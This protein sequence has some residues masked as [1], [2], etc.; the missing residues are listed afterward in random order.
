MKLEKLL[1][2]NHS[3]SV[4]PQPA[5]AY[6]GQCTCTRIVAPCEASAAMRDFCSVTLA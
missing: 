2:V 5:F 3:G 1:E 4:Y 6:P